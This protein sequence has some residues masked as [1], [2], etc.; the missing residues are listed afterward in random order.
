MNEPKSKRRLKLAGRQ[1]VLAKIARREAMAA[2]A[3]AVGEEVRSSDLAQ[4]SRD[5]VS[6]YGRRVDSSNGH[7]LRDQAVFVRRLQEVSDQAS[8]AFKDANDQAQ[9]Q[10]QT[11]AAAETRAKRFK[12]RMQSAEREMEAIQTKREHASAAGLAHKLQN[13]Q[14]AAGDT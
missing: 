13:K 14:K 6:E 9:W 7:S 8:Q 2:L 3:D 10:A 1:L 5:F 12:E 11:L 4:R